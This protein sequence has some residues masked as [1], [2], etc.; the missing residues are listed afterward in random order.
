MALLYIVLVEFCF[1]S[2]S[3]VLEAS[4]RIPVFLCISFHFFFSYSSFIQKFFTLWSDQRL[5]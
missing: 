4:V 5:W 1:H 3:V 2:Y